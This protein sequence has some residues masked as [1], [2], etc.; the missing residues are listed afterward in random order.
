MVKHLR[1]KLLHY[2]CMYFYNC[3]KFFKNNVDV[4]HLYSFPHYYLYVCPSVCH[5][6]MY[7]PNLCL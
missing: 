5:T 2:V 4:E 1:R 3:F 6:L 7:G